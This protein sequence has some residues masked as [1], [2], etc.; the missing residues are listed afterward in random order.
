[1]KNK[2]RIL[3][4]E[5]IFIFLLFIIFILLTYNYS[6]TIMI[7]GMLIFF[8]IIYCLIVIS[9]IRFNNKTVAWAI[10]NDNKILKVNF[11][12][13]RCMAYLY[14]RK[15]VSILGPSYIKS[16]QLEIMSNP[17]TVIKMIEGIPNTNIKVIEITKINYISNKRHSILIHCDYKIM[18]TNIVRQN[19]IISLE[20]SYDQIDYLI[21]CLNEQK[22]VI[23]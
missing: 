6:L 8:I 7:I 10:T 3:K 4:K 13:R 22:K 17:D 23:K 12:S 5:I 15:S 19:K 18:G 2:N 20:K 21:N 14:G 1:M 16:K 11:I 9:A